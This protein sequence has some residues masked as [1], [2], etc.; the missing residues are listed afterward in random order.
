MSKDYFDNDLKNY[1]FN[2]Y[3]IHISTLIV[4]ALL[5]FKGMPGPRDNGS[6]LP[7]GLI[8]M[9]VLVW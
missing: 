6:H 7:G 4:L 5:T 3:P 9:H 8:E 1:L 2:L